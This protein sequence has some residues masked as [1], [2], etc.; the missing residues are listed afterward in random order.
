MPRPFLSLPIQIV[1]ICR[2]HI[3][4]LSRLPHLASAHEQ[5]TASILVVRIESVHGRHFVDPRLV[6][7]NEAPHLD[8]ESPG[9]RSLE[10]RV[11]LPKNQRNLK[12]VEKLRLDPHLMK[13]CSL[14]EGFIIGGSSFFTIILFGFG[15]HI[16]FIL[17]VFFLLLI[18]SSP[19][20]IGEVHAWTDV[21][22][23]VIVSILVLILILI[24]NFVSV[25][26]SFTGSI[27]I[28]IATSIIVAPWTVPTPIVAV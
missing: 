16:I 28:S 3:V 1:H 19:S 20:F 25:S 21:F 22:G 14:G 11:K 7:L 18:I 6:S 2:Y 8:S 17:F 12:A 10:K 15:F 26:V 4:W 27:A 23:L 9:N 24:L 5:T 13:L